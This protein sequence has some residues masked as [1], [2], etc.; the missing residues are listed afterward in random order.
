LSNLNKNVASINF[1]QRLGVLTF[2]SKKY[3]ERGEIEHNTISAVNTSELYVPISHE[4]NMIN[5]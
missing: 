1:V 4:E 5:V 2:I 3:D